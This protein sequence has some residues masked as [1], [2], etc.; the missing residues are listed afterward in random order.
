[1]FGLLQDL[2]H[3]DPCFPAVSLHQGPV[4]L[5]C[6]SAFCPA[7]RALHKLRR[8]S[9]SS[10]GPPPRHYRRVASLQGGLYKGRGWGQVGTTGPWLLTAIRVGDGGSVQTVQPVSDEP[11]PQRSAGE[12]SG[13]GAASDCID[14]MGPVVSTGSG[15]GSQFER[16]C[17]KAR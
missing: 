2:P 12:G 15:T 4:G 9:V 11:S 10:P 5:P 7:S 8:F 6:C 13:M 3:G 1:V 17:G 14:K 16:D